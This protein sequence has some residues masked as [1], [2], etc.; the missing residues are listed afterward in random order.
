MSKHI[1]YKLSY[2]FFMFWS[3]SAISFLIVHIAPNSF[4]AS[5][6]LNPN[7]T[8]EALEN[9]K[10]IYGLEKPLLEQYLTWCK[11]I[12]N[13]DFGISFSS[14]KS[15]KDEILSR[16]GITLTINLVSM[17]FIF[18]IS[19]V[20]GILAGLGQGGKFDGWTKNFSALSFAIPSFYLAILF[21]GFFSIYLGI[22]PISGLHSQGMQEPLGLAYWS[23]Y[24]KHLILPLS[25]IIL[26]GVGSMALYVRSLSVE[27]LKSD[28]LFFAKARGA[29][30]KRVIFS[31]ILPNLS[32][33]MITMLGMSL[34]AVIG[35]SV[36]IESIFAINGMGLLFF[37]AALSRDY[38][39]ILGITMTGAFLTL[40]GNIIADL[41]LLKLNPF[42]KTGD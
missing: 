2:M 29:G 6:E 38:P 40:L 10:K 7:I 20:V 4:L 13:L 11:S 36:L 12:A 28:Y 25:V 9:L 1:L 15:V 22:L 33:A 35:G 37:Q 30:N 34:P 31:Y 41:A 24:A 27:I 19:L 21:I 14:G 5:G 32:P 8:A 17:F 42:I 23:D 26:T 18:A 3:I 39:V 16:L